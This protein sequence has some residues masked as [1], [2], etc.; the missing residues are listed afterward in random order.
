[1]RRGTHEAQSSCTYPCGLQ[2]RDEAYDADEL[3][4]T[5]PLQ[6]ANMLGLQERRSKT[7]AEFLRAAHS[8]H[9]VL[10]CRCATLGFDKIF[11]L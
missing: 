3:E 4:V 9:V 8:A 7:Y 6:L 5:L 11:I 10:I 1:M 2:D